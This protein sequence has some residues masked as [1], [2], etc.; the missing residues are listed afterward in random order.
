MKINHALRDPLVG[1]AIESGPGLRSTFRERPVGS[2]FLAPAITASGSARR[3]ARAA[4]SRSDPSYT[5][6]CNGGPYQEWDVHPDAGTSS[7]TLIDH[8]TGLCL[9][10]NA[11]GN[12][13]THICNGGP[14]QFWGVRSDLLVDT[15]T[16]VDH[17]TGL[18]LDSNAA[19]TSY[20]HVCNGGTF[21]NWGVLG[22]WP[23]CL[24]NCSPP[25]TRPPTPVVTTPVSTPL[26]LP[27][28]PHELA[29]KLVLKWTRRHAVT[30]LDAAK[31]GS[32]PRRLQISRSVSR[33]EMPS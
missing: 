12:D 19:G 8:Q 17:E 18:C 30:R 29:V 14:Y 2:S 5:L 6:S 33:T 4:L 21:Q 15:Y 24:A 11:G 9:H 27:Q 10:S 13:Y 32:F 31:I 26:P 1:I 22:G 7:Y 3:I 16:L 28:T 25:P 23:F 20:T